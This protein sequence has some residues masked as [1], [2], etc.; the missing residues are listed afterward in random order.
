MPSGTLSNKRSLFFAEAF[1][2][3]NLRL[4]RRLRRFIHTLCRG[5]FV[6]GIS[7]F[8]EKRTAF[9][10]TTRGLDECE[11]FVF[12]LDPTSAAA[13]NQLF[14]FAL[15]AKLLKT[16]ST[17]RGC[18]ANSLFL[19]ILSDKSHNSRFPRIIFKSSYP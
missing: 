14:N 11:A 16:F 18:S 7:L 15:H 3:C 10:C 8:C 12:P 2:S 4:K 1:P 6:K 19:F 13:L 9:V 5:A 17:S